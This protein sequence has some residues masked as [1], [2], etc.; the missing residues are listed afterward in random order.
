MCAVVDFLFQ[1]Y[2]IV[3]SRKDK[4]A[5]ARR[6]CNSMGGNL[7][8]IVSRSDQGMLPIV[9]SHIYI[10]S[11]W[12]VKKNGRFFWCVKNVHQTTKACTGLQFGDAVFFSAFLL[13][14]MSET[15]SGDLWIGL[16]SLEKG[17]FFWTDGRPRRYTNWGFNV[18]VGAKRQCVF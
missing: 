3:N 7:A 10:W 12:T 11:D 9:Q 17:E 5:E 14:R 16:N 4:W 2:R 1:C 18:S 13:T 6:R 8:S 15:G